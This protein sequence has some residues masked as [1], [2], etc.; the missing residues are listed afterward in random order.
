[1]RQARITEP[2]SKSRTAAQSFTRSPGSDEVG[3][4][5]NGKCRESCRVIDLSVGNP[6]SF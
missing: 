3:S 6:Y 1:M 2:C 5:V 4:A